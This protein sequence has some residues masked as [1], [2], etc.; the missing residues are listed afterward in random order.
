MVGLLGPGSHIQSYT[1]VCQ[2]GNAPMMVFMSEETVVATGGS[3]IKNLGFA[4]DNTCQ[5]LLADHIGSCGMATGLDNLSTKKNHQKFK[6]PQNIHK[7]AKILIIL[8]SFFNKI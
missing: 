7:K 6:N 4:I 5:A 2:C 1:P 8:S 3:F